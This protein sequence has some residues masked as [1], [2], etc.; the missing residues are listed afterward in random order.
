MVKEYRKVA[1]RLSIHRR[2]E[3]LSS[4]DGVKCTSRYYLK[5][6]HLCVGAARKK[7]DDNKKGAVTL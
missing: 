2:H 3:A 1:R 4:L 5:L 7:A 6:F